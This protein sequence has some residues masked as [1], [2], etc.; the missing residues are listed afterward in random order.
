MNGG[1]Y[2][3]RTIDQ[4][5]QFIKSASAAAMG[6]TLLA[7]G[8]AAASTPQAGKSR[9]VLIRDLGVLD[10]NGQPR[11]AAVQEML[12]AGITALTGRPDAPSRLE[13]AHPSG[14]RRRP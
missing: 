3:T 11:A 2:E 14:R 12:D 5:R 9:V 13:D 8:R 4:P 7:R 6:T 10:E 1:P